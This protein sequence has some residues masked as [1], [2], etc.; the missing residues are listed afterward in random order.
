M[1]TEENTATETTECFWN[2]FYSG[3]FILQTDAI[4][5]AEN[6]YDL[7]EEC[8]EFFRE[9][10][11]NVENAGFSGLSANNKTRWNSDSKMAQSRIKNKG[12][13][14]VLQCWFVYNYVSSTSCRYCQ[15]MS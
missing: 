10:I 2:C 8:N 15:T 12:R 5:E 14:S 9:A 7:A 11:E 6:Q 13:H 4:L 3:I 1:S